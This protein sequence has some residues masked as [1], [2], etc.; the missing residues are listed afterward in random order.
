MES[1][2]I[3]FKVEGGKD[4]Y[5]NWAVIHRHC[6]DQYHTEEKARLSRGGKF[7]G[8]SHSVINRGGNIKISVVP[9]QSVVKKI[10]AA[11]HKTL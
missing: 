6:H 7:K 1:H 8:E 5:K 10:Q 9:L 4:E 3:R 11:L 2:H